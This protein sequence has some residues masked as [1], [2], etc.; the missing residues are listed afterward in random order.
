LF[1]RSFVP[2]SSF[3]FP[4]DIDANIV[5]HSRK[6]IVNDI[7]KHPN[8]LPKVMKMVPRRGP[9]PPFW[10]PRGGLDLPFEP[11]WVPCGPTVPPGSILEDFGGHLGGHFELKI[12]EIW[13]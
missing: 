12:C 2:S 10:G 3:I 9:G 1:V 5:R 4:L 8:Q 6:E 13:C 11:L 7:E